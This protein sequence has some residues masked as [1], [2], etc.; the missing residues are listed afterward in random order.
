M[1]QENKYKLNFYKKRIDGNVYSVCDQI[2]SNSD[3][4]VLTFINSLSVVEIQ[5]FIE[6]LKECI[7]SKNNGN[8]GFE[9]DGVEH[10]SIKYFYPDV[11]IDGVL[12]IPMI[13]LK[14]LL[15]EWLNFILTK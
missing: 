7:E 5:G 9:S 2:I 12:K 8:I 3:F 15:E 1:K 6:Q 14:E 10:M 13:D 4:S 11:D